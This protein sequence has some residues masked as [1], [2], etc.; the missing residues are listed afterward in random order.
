[1]SRPKAGGIR[2][3]V[4]GRPSWKMAIQEARSKELHKVSLEVQL[5]IR[6]NPLCFPRF[7][8]LQFTFTSSRLREMHLGKEE[9]V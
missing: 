2:T 6:A 5:N 8:P 9:E 1:M 3:A 7:P 4:R